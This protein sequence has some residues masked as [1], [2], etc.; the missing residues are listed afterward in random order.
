MVYHGKPCFELN[1]GDYI[2]AHPLCQDVNTVAAESV[3]VVLIVTLAGE[4]SLC[5]GARGVFIA[6]AVV[7][8]AFVDIYTIDKPGC[9]LKVIGRDQ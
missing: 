4:T 3:S 5:V 7:N 6:S 8:E 9:L 1:L 2:I